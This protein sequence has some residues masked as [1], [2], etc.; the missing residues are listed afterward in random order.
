MPFLGNHKNLQEY[1]V[2]WTTIKLSI[3]Y[4]I[5]F[6]DFFR[7]NIRKC[8]VVYRTFYF[9]ADSENKGDGDDER[10]ATGNS[11]DV[12]GKLISLI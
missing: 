12:N 10:D 4:F 8:L 1:I 6:G 5:N 11:L 2:T 3:R 7:Y 9:T